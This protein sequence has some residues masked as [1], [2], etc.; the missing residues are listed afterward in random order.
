MVKQNA[1]LDASFWINICSSTVVE[2]VRDYFILYV[3]TVVAQEIR[4]P[5]DVLGIEAYSPTLFNRW[6]QNGTVTVQDPKSSVNWYQ[7]GENGAIAL[8]LEHNYL[9]LIDDA[10]PYH[11]AKAAG[12]R[13]VGTAEFII[14]LY[15]HERLNYEAAANAIRQIRTSKRQKRTAMIVLETLKRLKGK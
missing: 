6:V 9:L 13:V 7:Q 3:P 12:L 4:Y 8:A 14:L 2:Y 11:R 1:S 15:D 10:N 5:L